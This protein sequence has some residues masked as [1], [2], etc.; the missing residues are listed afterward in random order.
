M[1]Y[2][3]YG[4]S[5]FLEFENEKIIKEVAEKNQGLAPQIFDSSLK[6]EENFLVS[7]QTNSIFGSLEFLILKRAEVLKSNNIAKL[8]KSLKNYDL[9]KKIVLISYNLPMQYDKP[10]A[11]YELTKAVIKNIEEIATFIDCTAI[12]EKNKISDYIKEKLKISDKDSKSLVE[13][14]PN[15]YYTIKNE[16]DK[17]AIFLDGE[18]YSFEKVKN[19]I[20]LDKEYNLKDLLESFLKNKDVSALLEYISKNKDSYMSLI[21]I[22]S[23]ELITLIKLSS[24][25]KDGRISK[26][27][28]YNVFKEVYED[29]SNLFMA[30]NFR[31]QHPY[32]I[33]LK[34]NS[35]E[36]ENEEFY[37]KKLR[38]L[39]EIE[40]KMK[41]GDMDIE[42]E[43]PL[44]LYSF[45]E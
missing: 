21:Y 19:L 23:D 20:S 4:N 1:F 29:F 32:T 5:P 12:K 24:L 41:S 31:P 35:F 26:S 14:L 11:E 22:L 27:M 25:I 38:N 37:Q 36:I 2:F 45:F 34:L 17:L 40:F 10:V 8:I 28:S 9:S 13:S 39:L 7:L 43:L 30:K 3:C 15:D 42:I 44:Y 18:E 16:I 6:E 33:Y